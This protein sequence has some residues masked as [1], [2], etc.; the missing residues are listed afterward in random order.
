MLN[1]IGTLA[2]V[3]VTSPRIFMWV[4]IFFVTNMLM[5]LIDVNS[6]PVKVWKHCRLCCHDQGPCAKIPNNKGILKGEYL[7][8]YKKCKGSPCQKCSISL[9]SYSSILIKIE[10][11]VISVGFSMG[12]NL[13]TKVTFLC[14]FS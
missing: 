13:I 11:K 5:I 4:K 6:N 12:G 9:E 1:H 8:I 3:P 10:F 7:N 14:L 2:T